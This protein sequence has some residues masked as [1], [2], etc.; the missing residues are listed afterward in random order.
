MKRGI[1]RRAK[2]SGRGRED[3]KGR[4]EREWKIKDRMV[5]GKGRSGEE[6]RKEEI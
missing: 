4:K 5:T 2:K 3:K 6:E 1:K